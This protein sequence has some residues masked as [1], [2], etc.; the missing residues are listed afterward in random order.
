MRDGFPA[1]TID[2]IVKRAGTTKPAFYRRF[3]QVGDMI[4][5]I[6]SSRHDLNAHIDEGS[7]ELDLIAFQ[8]AQRKIFDDPLVR[9]GMAGWLAYLTAHQEQA[10]TFVNGFLGPRTETLVAILMRAA[11]RKEFGA[12]RNPGVIMDILVGPMLMRSMLP[13]FESIDDRL[14]SQTVDVALTYLGVRSPAKK[15][16]SRA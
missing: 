11:L 1:V 13:G 3:S 10:Q 16:V 12:E 15:A 9:Q 7:L 2:A 14:V 5:A 4:P 6:I 8:E